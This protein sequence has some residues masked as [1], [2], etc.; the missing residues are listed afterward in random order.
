[1]FIVNINVNQNEGNC[2]LSHVW[3]DLVNGTHSRNHESVLIRSKVDIN[4]N[5]QQVRLFACVALIN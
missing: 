5:K 2:Q 4:V 3:D 1:M